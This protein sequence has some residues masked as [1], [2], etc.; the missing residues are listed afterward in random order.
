M[1]GSLGIDSLALLVRNG[2]EMNVQNT[3]H[4]PLS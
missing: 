1:T 3:I 4:N 2:D